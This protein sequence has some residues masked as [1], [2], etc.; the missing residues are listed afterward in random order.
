MPKKQESLNND[1]F[2][3]LQS[4]GYNPV[5]LDT[6]GKEIPVADEAEVFQFHFIKDD[7]DYGTATVSIDGLRKLVIYFGDKIANSPKEGTNDSTSWYHL[8]RQ[9]KRFAQQH[10]LSFETRNIDK[11]EPDMAKRSYTKKL[12]EAYHAINKKTSYNDSVP[13]VKV[14]IQHK[15]DMAEGEQRFRQI[16]KIFIENAVGERILAPT[17]KPGIA[18]VYGRHIAEGGK[19]N[20]AR[21]DQITSLCEEYQKMAGF[22]RATRNG[23]FNESAQRLVTEGINHYQ[24]LRETL[25]KMT[26]KR[27]YNAYFESFTPSLMEDEEQ[28]DLSEM[29]MSSSLDPRIESVMPILG[30]LSKN[31]GEAKDMEE[32]IALEAWADSISEG[33]SETIRLGQFAAGGG[34]AGGQNPAD[35]LGEVDDDYVDPE[36]ADYGD[37]YQDTVKRAGQAVGSINQ[38]MGSPDMVSL[39]KRLHDILRTG[40]ETGNVL[41]DEVT[42]EDI[43]PQQAEVNKIKQTK[44]A[45]D[46]EQNSVGQL[47]PTE[48]ITK[49]NPTQGKLVGACESTD[50]ADIRRLSGL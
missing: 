43:G 39:A 30:K 37:E 31:L 28:V 20:D 18:K 11:L 45:L 22:V 24:S 38:K 25:S 2:K 4:R 3:L 16:D 6:T 36:E 42:A 13:T 49:S 41:P 35:I 7:E 27:G 15:R 26:G 34:V 19:P 29:F 23:Q 21:W 10:Q 9:I 32:I 50:L 12:D 5:M 40:K 14:R 17:I 46:P 44:E 48:K 47:G 33:P 1:L 8:L